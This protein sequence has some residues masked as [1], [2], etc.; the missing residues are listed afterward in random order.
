MGRRES[1]PLEITMVVTVVAGVV[2]VG[3]VL[4]GI[5]VTTSTTSVVTSGASVVVSACTALGVTCGVGVTNSWLYT[6]FTKVSTGG[7][8]GEGCTGT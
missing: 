1:T 5:S 8:G 4:G 7:G 3:V 6:G 2:T